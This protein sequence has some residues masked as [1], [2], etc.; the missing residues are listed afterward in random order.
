MLAGIGQR[1]I[2]VFKQL[3]DATH[4]TSLTREAPKKGVASGAR[5]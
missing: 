3:L 5:R 4:D 1:Q 2:Q